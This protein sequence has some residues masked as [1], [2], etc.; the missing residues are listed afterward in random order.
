V[1]LFFFQYLSAFVTR[2]P[3][4]PAPAGP[5]GLLTTIVGLASVLVTNLIVVARSCCWPA[6]GACPS[7]PWPWWRAWARPG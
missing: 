4:T 6:A 1:L 3:S 2:A 7:A 5:D